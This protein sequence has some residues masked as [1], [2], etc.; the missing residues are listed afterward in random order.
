MQEAP[1]FKEGWLTKQGG[2]IRSWKKRWFVLQGNKLHYY[3]DQSKQQLQGTIPLEGSNVNIDNDNVHGKEHCLEIV[4]ASRT[5]PIVA[6]DAPDMESWMNFIL[7]ASLWQP[8]LQISGPT[9]I[10]DATAT[11]KV[12]GMM[13]ECCNKEIQQLVSGMGNVKCDIDMDKDIVVIS[14][15]FD[16]GKAKMILEDAGYFVYDA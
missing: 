12:K 9:K 14:G 4:T 1:V 8:G 16:R 7:K 5:Y 11:M 6:Q 3:L 15:R 2:F 13:S 10:E